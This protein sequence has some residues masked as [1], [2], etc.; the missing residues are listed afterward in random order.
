MK[1]FKLRRL[2]FLQLTTETLDGQCECHLLSLLAETFFPGSGSASKLDLDLNVK[3]TFDNFLLTFIMRFNLGGAL[4][5]SGDN[6]S[7][8]EVIS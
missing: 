4:P 8:V 5:R 3:L 6:I 1:D 7:R 2:V